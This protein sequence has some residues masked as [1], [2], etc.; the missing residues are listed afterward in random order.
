M[1]EATI[2]KTITGFFSNHKPIMLKRGQVII[3]PNEDLN[4]I[5]Y[6]K[7]G[8]VKMY[9]LSEEGDELTLHLFTARSFFP[10]MLRLS[11]KTN[12][13]Y[14]EAV[15]DSQGMIAPT[16]EVLKWLKSEPEVLFDLTSRFSSAIMGLLTRIEGMAF[17]DAF[18]KM[19]SLIIYLAEKFGEDREGVVHITLILNHQDIASWLSI[20]RETASRQ[21]EK[22]QKTGL[23]QVKD[24]HIII[25]NLSKLKDVIH[26]TAS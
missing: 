11:G 15:E 4:S 3:R 25:P 8:V 18:A 21:L 26:I 13:Y 23:I 24:Q 6:L 17:Q 1:T 5:I 9:T 16:E 12:A 22:L 20:R 7:T 14:Y 2:E 10:M 19:V